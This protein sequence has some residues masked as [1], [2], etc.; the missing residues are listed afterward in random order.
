MPTTPNLVDT[1]THKKKKIPTITFS[2]YVLHLRE[3]IFISIQD[4]R[5]SIGRYRRYTPDAWSF[6]R[7]MPYPAFEQLGQKGNYYQ[8]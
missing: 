5:F 6:V 8:E 7:W 4:P 3:S 2:V 1:H